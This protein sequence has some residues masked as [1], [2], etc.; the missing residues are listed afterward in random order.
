MFASRSR[1]VVGISAAAA[2]TILSGCSTPLYPLNGPSGEAGRYGAAFWDVPAGSPVV[3]TLDTFCLHHGAPDS[4]TATVT[5]IEPIEAQGIE[6]SG[7]GAYRSPDGFFTW[8]MGPASLGEVG[9]DPNHHEIGASCAEP[10]ELLVEFQRTDAEQVGSL[11][12]VDIHYRLSN[13]L[14]SGVVRFHLSLALC[15]EVDETDPDCDPPSP[16]E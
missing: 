1:I 11:R 9:I 7:F 8:H 3:M 2:V 13:G 14:G 5:D 6:V 10:T 15:G 12:A 16:L 4:V